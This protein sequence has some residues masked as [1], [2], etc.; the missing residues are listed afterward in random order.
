MSPMP[1]IVRWLLQLGPLNPIA[2]RLVHNGSRRQRHFYIRAT[3]LA[4]LILL[5]LWALISQ[6]RGG[7]DDYRALAKAGAN[8]FTWIAYVQVGLIC[9]LAPVFMAGAVGQEADP[10]TW[11][12][13]LSTPLTPAQ[14]VLGNL[15][16]R[17]FFVLALLVA[18]LPLFAITQ[19]F[20]GVPGSSILRSYLIAACAAGL[21]GAI[22]ISLSVS[23]LVG[24][25]AVFAFYVAVVSYLALTLAV[26][27]WLQRS[28]AG[29]TVMTALNPFLALRAL[30][31]PS[32]YPAAPTGAPWML[33]EPVDAWCWGS[34]VLAVVL[35]VASACT[36]RL[37]GL[38]GLLARTGGVPW[39]RRVF[40]L[41]AAGAEHRPPRHVWHNPIAWREAAARNATLGR[42][43]ARWSFI[44]LGAAMSIGI[45]VM[46]HVGTLD[47]AS[48][49][50]V[51]LSVVWGE[52]A[53][54]TLVTINMAAT[55]I[56][57]ER[58]D[59]TLDLLLTTPITP[60]MYLSG[61]LRG[62]IAYLLPMIA[63]P[64]GTML[65]AGFYVAL[66]GAAREGGVRVT[67][68]VGTGALEMPVVLPEAALSVPLVSMGFIALAAMIGLAW[69]LKSRGTLSAVI[70]SFAIVIVI[71]GTLGLCGYKSALEIEY[72]G[73][74]LAGL[75][76][77]SL[78]F[79][80]AQPGEAL[81]TSVT[82]GSAT[83]ARIAL[84]IGALV[85]TAACVGAIYAI[86]LSMVRTFDFT[87][88]KLAGGR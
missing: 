31:N 9:I 43:A 67:E 40:G 72:I 44:G 65:L 38:Q 32:G 3:Y 80:A 30:L 37:G 63:V 58:E 55:A 1:P 85:A 23:R 24:R 39:Y 49:R 62:L 69:S 70:T 57:R 7:G 46:Y 47:H 16:G 8:S 60:G 11:D 42:I 4:V 61:K 2:V 79:A 83:N 21:V 41:G 19:Y 56:T 68:Q 34:L 59:G 26:D 75:S 87:T 84:F 20:G 29:V 71:G 13:L 14:I 17:L 18:S 15:G 28:G 81:A 35:V 53:V 66:A 86:H 36:V 76:P 12:I 5:L 73:P 45:V 78:V 54:L 82:A 50:F 74:F 64:A 48:F 22:A 88:R 6:T 25:R 51:L 27:A 77:A 10:K 52:L 33:R